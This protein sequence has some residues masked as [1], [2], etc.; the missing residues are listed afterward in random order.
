M[1][2]RGQSARERAFSFFYNHVL[3][4]APPAGAGLCIGAWIKFGKLEGE[5]RGVGVSKEIEGCME[6]VVRIQGKWLFLDILDAYNAYDINLECIDDY[7]ITRTKMGYCASCK[8]WRKF[9]NENIA[10]SCFGHL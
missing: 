9:F 1:K 7:E 5:I 2:K 10:D 8:R 3:T 6:I 4:G